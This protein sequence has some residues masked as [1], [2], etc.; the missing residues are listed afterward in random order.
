[1]VTLPSTLLSVECGGLLGGGGR[2]HNN[3]VPSPQVI[4]H[5]QVEERD[6]TANVDK[7][8]TKRWRIFTFNNQQKGSVILLMY[9]Q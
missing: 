8:K 4:S 7:H 5:L 3:T 2:E 9:N 6:N 1:M